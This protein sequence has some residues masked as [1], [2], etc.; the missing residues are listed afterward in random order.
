MGNATT[1]VRHQAQVHAHETQVGAIVWADAEL[2]ST[3]LLRSDVRARLLANGVDPELQP[4]DPTT[5]AAFGHALARADLPRG[6]KVE[7][8]EPRSRTA[9]LF[10][11]AGAGVKRVDSAR[12]QLTAG[13]TGVDT[14]PDRAQLARPELEALAP[15]ESEYTSALLYLRATEIQELLRAALRTFGATR[16]RPHSG[17]YYVPA[18]AI[19]GA[20]RLA[21]ALEGLGG[22]RVV[23]LPL[24]DGQSKMLADDLADGLDRERRAVLLGLRQIIEARDKVR[25][26]TFETRLEELNE[27]EVRVGVAAEML[28]KRAHELATKLAA[29][30]SH[31]RKLALGESMNLDRLV[32]EF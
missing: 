3:K 6:W 17:T 13:P 31:V 20:Q 9:L 26:S 22:T 18:S 10:E 21:K 29:A 15:I 19:D 27:L 12:V 11:V 7:R 30:R 28:G 16:I 8:S 23:V 24:F 1:L 14:T 5:Q 4:A 2:G 32:E 25:P